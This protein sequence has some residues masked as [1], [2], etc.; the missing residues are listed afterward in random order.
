MKETR[1]ETGGKSR[2]RQQRGPLR[3]EHAIAVAGLIVLGVALL[4]A[5]GDRF[6]L[7]GRSV[8]AAVSSS[9]AP[10]RY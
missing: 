8:V 4:D 2:R 3:C 6:E 5:F 7:V 1:M 9:S 10:T